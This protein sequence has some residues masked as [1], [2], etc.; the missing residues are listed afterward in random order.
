MQRLA[1]VD[2]HTL[3]YKHIHTKVNK[4]ILTQRFRETH[5]HTNI[6]VDELRQTDAHLD[7][8]TYTMRY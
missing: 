2:T 4:D 3:I 1:Q 5:R 6:L 7:R 8:H